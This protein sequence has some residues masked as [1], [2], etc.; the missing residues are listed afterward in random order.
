MAIQDIR[1]QYLQEDGFGKE[2][3][4]DLIQSG[5]MPGG[6]S[7]GGGGILFCY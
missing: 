3:I 4:L 7:V 1:N 6:G 5:A 2:Y